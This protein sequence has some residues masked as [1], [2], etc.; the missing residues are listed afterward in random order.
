MAAVVRGASAIVAEAGVGTSRLRGRYATGKDP[1]AYDGLG[2]LAEEFPT[3]LC[4]R[5]TTHHAVFQALAVF[6]SQIPFGQRTP[7]RLLLQLPNEEK[8]ILV[9]PAPR[10]FP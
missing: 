6:H 7:G 1:A 8:A 3:G 2:R 5:R 9:G 10:V 4:R